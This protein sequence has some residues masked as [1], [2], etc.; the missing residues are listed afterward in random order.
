MCVF[1]SYRVWVD[2][3]LT[4]GEKETFELCLRRL[5]E[6]EATKG[7]AITLTCPSPEGACLKTAVGKASRWCVQLPTV[8]TASLVWSSPT[9]SIPM[10]F[11][12]FFVLFVLFFLAVLFIDVTNFYTLLDCF[13]FFAFADMN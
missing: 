6:S 1:I 9:V 12:L 13:F 11:V 8:L 3:C 2:E 4:G 7:N 10:C 5:W